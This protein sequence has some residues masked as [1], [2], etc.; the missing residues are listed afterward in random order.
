MSREDWSKPEHRAR[1]IAAAQRAL[2]GAVELMKDPTKLEAT[3]R[4]L[5]EQAMLGFSRALHEL[6]IVG[7]DPAMDEGAF[8]EI[9]DPFTPGRTLLVSY[10][11]TVGIK[12]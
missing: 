5:Q 8:F 1:L 10:R 9:P 11:C 2:Q 6:E 4:P 7:K 3:M 12:R